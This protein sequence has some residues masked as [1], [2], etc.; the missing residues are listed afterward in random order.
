M[1]R[2]RRLLAAAASLIVMLPSLAAAQRGYGSDGA[3]S[4]PI[5]FGFG[6]GMSVPTSNYKDAF[7]TGVNG[8]G[9]IGFS[10]PGVPITLRATAAYNHFNLKETRLSTSGTA[11]PTGTAATSGHSDI[12]GGIGNLT[13]RFPKGPIRPYIMAGVGAFNVKQVIDYAQSSGAAATP[14]SVSS[15]DFGVDGGAG[16]ELKLF[17]ASAFVEARMSNVYTKKDRFRNVES[18]KYIPVT[19][20]FLF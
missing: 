4:R 12:L 11:L 14:Q 9:F 20:G 13:F 5:H 10:L 18:A 8:Q 19:F 6:G 1:I 17:G 3:S 15:T 2:I 16:L 7:K